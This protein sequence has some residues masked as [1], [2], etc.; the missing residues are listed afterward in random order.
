[1][2][3]RFCRSLPWWLLAVS[4]WARTPANV[5]VVINENS[6]LS[7]SIGDYYTQ[8]RGI[9]A[10]NVCRISSPE[11]ETIERRDF[12]A[13][14]RAPLAACLRSRRLNEQILYIV[15]TAGLPLRIHGTGGPDGDLAA[16]DSE[17]T[18]LYGFLKSG[19]EHPLKGPLANPFFG[20][21]NAAFTHPEFPMYLVT[22]LAAYDLA[23]ARALVD[24]ALAARNRGRFVIDLSGDNDQAGNDWLRDAVLRLPA[25][26]VV[27]DASPRVLR[28][29]KDVIGYASWG[30]NDPARKERTLEFQWLPGAI[31][32]EYVST[33]ARTFARPPKDWR[34]SDWSDAS[35]P[36][37]FAG[38]PQSL[39]ADYLAEGASAATGHVYEPFLAATPRPD[40]L[41]PAYFQG[42]NLA[43]SFYLSI[44][45]L[46]WQNIVV[47]DPLMSLG[48]PAK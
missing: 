41:L 20:K 34:L 28:R 47:G 25:D 19:R 15:T 38:S 12:D 46:S 18:L 27:F 42:R 11:A 44:P 39:A 32:T 37:W 40:L 26:R 6:A 2:Y 13:R 14:L 35:R 22:R 29:Q 4:A 23:G 33:N 17:L 3:L 16:V 43:E 10:A 45:A 21:R 30:S 8:K 7:R 48:P 5:L 9:P 24:R 36:K 31:A 1:M